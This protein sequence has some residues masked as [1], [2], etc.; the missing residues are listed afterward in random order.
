MLASF[1]QKLTFKFNIEWKKVIAGAALVLVVFLLF[2]YTVQSLSYGLSDD[3]H[4][5]M[6]I[7]NVI[8][9][10]SKTGLRWGAIKLFLVVIFILGL[11]AF[12]QAKQRLKKDERNFHYANSGVYGTAGLLSTEEL[13]GL[14]EIT[15]PAKAE[16][17]ILAQMDDSGKNLVVKLTDTMGY[18]NNTAIFGPPGSGKS[19]GYVKSNIIQCCKRRESLI[20]TDPKGELYGDSVAYLK[21]NGYIIRRLDLV[22]LEMSDTWD[23]LSEITNYGPSLQMSRSRIFAEVVMNNIVRDPAK[24]IFFAQKLALL[25]ALILRVAL[26]NDYGTPENPRTLGQAYQILNRHGDNLAYYFSPDNNPEAQL[27]IDCFNSFKNGSENFIG[28][29]ISGLSTGLQILA[30]PMIQKITGESR[31]DMTLPGQKPCAYFLVLSDKNTVYQFLSS[32]FFSFCFQDL[33]DFADI[34]KDRKLPVPVNFI[35]DEVKNVGTIPSLDK[36]MGTVRSRKMNIALIL[37]NL[38]QL[39]DMY[40]TSWGSVLETCTTQVA[41]GFNG[42]ETAEYFSARAG[43]ASVQVKTEQHPAYESIFRWSRNHSTGVGTRQVFTPDEL[44]RMDNKDILVVLQ[45]RNV[46]KA[47]KYYVFL[48][49]EYKKWTPIDVFEERPPNIDAKAIA[50]YYAEQDAAVAAFEAKLNEG[51]IPEVQ[52]MEDEPDDSAFGVAQKIVSAAKESWEER[53]IRAKKVKAKG[54]SL[55]QKKNRHEVVD[56]DDYAFSEPIHIDIDLDEQI[57]SLFAD[58]PAEDTTTAV[59]PEPEPKTEPASPAEEPVKEDSTQKQD[60][61]ATPKQKKPA[62]KKP[63]AKSPIK[64]K[65]KPAVEQNPEQEKP[66]PQAVNPWDM[67][68]TDFDDEPAP[69]IPDD[70]IQEEPE[71]PQEEETPPP[72]AEKEPAK[73][74][75]AKSSRFAHGVRAAEGEKNAANQ[76]SFAPSK[77][78]RLEEEDTASEGSAEPKKKGKQ[79]PMDKEDM[80]AMND[81]ANSGWLFGGPGW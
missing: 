17:E 77:T 61:P 8:A 58:I 50:E 26:G 49:P 46:L 55:F 51:Y 45:G 36:Y 4:G 21:A 70:M 1:I 7:G 62:A 31:I 27:A 67:E 48:H 47:R 14:G 41:L 35:L 52:R 80:E 64:E 2:V 3:Y 75:K 73:P 12:W 59:A 9:Y 19:L 44:Q 24:D 38:S 79:K 76:D 22:N 30:D 37:Q 6:S 16:G 34:Q 78:K 28:N 11:V 32:L 66:A 53:P 20:I 33:M 81:A 71:I 5:S 60:I 15:T 42:Q 57:D 39:K 10:T 65:P 54:A 43:E 69:D 72:P 18:N 25:Q 40:P 23:C 56:I 63:K 68:P 13:N 29:V 74:P